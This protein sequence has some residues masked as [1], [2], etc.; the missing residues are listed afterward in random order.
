[1][2]RLRAYNQYIKQLRV[3]SWLIFRRP[4]NEPPAAV[5]ELEV[6]GDD[7]VARIKRVGLLKL[8]PRRGQIATQHIRI[9]L[10]IQDLNGF[11]PQPDRLQISLVGKIKAT[12]PIIARCEPNPGGDVLR[13]LFDRILEIALG[14]SETSAIELLQP[15]PNRFIGRIIFDVGRLLHG[16]WTGWRNGR[17]YSSVTHSSV[18]RRFASCQGCGQQGASQPKKK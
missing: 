9:S 6:I 13:G 10:I 15:H 12:Q 5:E 14:K 1:M 7:G 4:F 3:V 16:V 18:L 11:A 17:N 8:S 2:A